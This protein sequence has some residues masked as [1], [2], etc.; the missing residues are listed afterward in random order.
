MVTI[1]T[2]QELKDDFISALETALNITIPTFGK[3]FLN[4]LSGVNAGKM[5]LYYTALGN[6]QK[7]VFPDTADLAEFG[8]TLERFAFVKGITRQPA[9]AGQYQV[10]VTGDVGAIIPVNSTWKSNDNSNSPGQLYILDTP[11]TLIAT[12]QVITLRALDAGLG[13]QLL[14]GDFLTA[15]AP[16]AL[17]GSDAEVTSEVVT[18]I[19]QESVED[20]RDRILQ[21]YQL[22]PQGGAGADYRIWGSEASGVK[23]IYPYTGSVVNQVDVYV[24]ATIADS[25]DSKGSAGASILADVESQI[26]DPTVD[27]PARKPINDVPVYISVTPLDVNITINGSSFTATQQ[28]NIDAALAEKIDEI[29]PYVGSIEPL[30]D[31]FDKISTNIIVGVILNAVPG[32]TFGTIDLEVDGSPVTEYQFTLGEIPYLNSVTYA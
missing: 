20:Y 18:P 7:N 22:E 1:K 2:L 15:T 3:N 12:T 9:I 27:R 11:V 28:A 17:V 25:T 19:S 31:Q 23:Q 5:F 21:A 26:E 4:A 8:G 32:S 10:A 16:I 13:S 29:R 30:S 14:V 6:V 24:E